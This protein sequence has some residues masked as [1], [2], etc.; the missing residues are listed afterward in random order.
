M[1]ESQIAQLDMIEN[2]VIYIKRMIHDAGRC[3]SILSR[4]RSASRTL[5]QV[6]YNI[7]KSHLESCVRKSFSEGNVLDKRK[8]MDEVQALPAQSR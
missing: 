7:F 1:H 4:I 8:R 2:E 3:I 6:E 5:S